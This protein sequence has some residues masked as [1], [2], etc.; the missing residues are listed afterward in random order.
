MSDKET[1]GVYASKAAEY[2]DLT[3]A[4]NTADPLLTAFIAETVPG[5]T[6]LDLGCGPGTS[7][8]LM[9]R[10]G[11]LVHAWDPVP[12]MVALAQQHPGV[13]ARVAGFDDLTETAVYDGIWA[14]YS[15]LHASRDAMPRHLSAITN[16]LRAGG[17]FHIA[18]K[19]GS[20]CKRDRLGRLYT[21]YSD[22]ELTSLLED[23]GLT[24]TG[25]AEGV[26]TGLDGSLS[27]WISLAA[28]A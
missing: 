21:Y 17:R 12:E 25:R 24:V 6:V 28:H 15:L 13:S 1:L 14:N 7:A 8:A 18:L 20:G 23:A 16:A 10:A 19:S 22:V 3:T 5:G 26:G 27:E 9:A 4:A 11:L 2:A